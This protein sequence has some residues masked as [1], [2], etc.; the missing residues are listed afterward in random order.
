MTR[1]EKKA[2][3]INVMHQAMNLASVKKL[4]LKEAIKQVMDGYKAIEAGL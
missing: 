1:E 4:P 2:I 3:A